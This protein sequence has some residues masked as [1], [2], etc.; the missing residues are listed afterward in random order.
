MDGKPLMHVTHINGNRFTCT[1]QSGHEPYQVILTQ[2]D[3][4]VWAYCSCPSSTNNKETGLCKHGKLVKWVA[5]EMN[6]PIYSKLYLQ[7][8]MRDVKQSK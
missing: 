8:S 1:S 3:G 5:E 7:A 4:A 6:H 2:Q